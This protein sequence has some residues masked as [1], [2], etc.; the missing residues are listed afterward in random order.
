MRITKSSLFAIFIGFMIMVAIS[1]SVVYNQRTIEREQLKETLSLTR[2]NLDSMDT[3]T[4]IYQQEELQ[5]DLDRAYKE[6]EADKAKF[7]QPIEDIA[8][9]KVLYATAKANRVNITAM[10]SS[11]IASEI[12]GGA[13]CDVLSLNARVVGKVDN[14][15]AF[16]TQLNDDLVNLVVRSVIITNHNSSSD[17]ISSADIRINI[18]KYEEQ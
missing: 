13:F 6:L 14:L 11:D 8:V 9:G 12:M 3:S 5:A 10:R 7:V 18:Y 16:I 1:L 4:L 15:V 2:F 17:N